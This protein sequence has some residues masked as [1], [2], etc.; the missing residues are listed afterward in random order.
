MPSANWQVRTLQYPPAADRGL[1]LQC[2]AA[3]EGW[4][5]IPQATLVGR[6]RPNMHPQLRWP[7]VPQPKLSVPVPLQAWINCPEL[8]P[9]TG[10]NHPTDQN[11]DQP[12]AFSQHCSVKSNYSM[13][14]VQRS[15][16]GLT[17]AL[18]PQ[19]RQAPH[20]CLLAGFVSSSPS[21]GSPQLRKTARTPAP[22]P[23]SGPRTNGLGSSRT[24][25]PAAR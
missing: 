12:R 16:G 2:L 1:P 20:K 6:R 8:R 13:K 19:Y 17:T 23:S 24:D 11:P 21:G 5:S 25:Q 14:C 3:R 9:R 18:P 10:P 4:R 22:E 7:K 15:S